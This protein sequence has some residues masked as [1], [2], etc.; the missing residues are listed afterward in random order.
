MIWL[1]T[2]E[3]IFATPWRFAGTVI[4]IVALGWA[5][6]GWTPLR[7]EIRNTREDVE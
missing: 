2:L 4:L 5:F 3:F 1:M 7:I 6:G